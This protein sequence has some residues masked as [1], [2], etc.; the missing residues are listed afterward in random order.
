M[1]IL[2]LD[3]IRGMHAMTMRIVRW[4]ACSVSLLVFGIGSARSQDGFDINEAERMFSYNTVEL[5]DQLTNGLR[6]AF[7]EQQAFLDQV[8]AKVDS[9][10]MSRAMVNVVFVWSRKRNP[11]IP[12]PYFEAVLRLLSEKRGITFE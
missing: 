8:V 12:F 4:M 6:V 5:K 7:P 9:G 10:E 3:L 11:R 1:A 2:V